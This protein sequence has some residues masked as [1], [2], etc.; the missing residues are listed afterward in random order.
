MIMGTEKLMASGITGES[1]NGS[2]KDTTGVI[3][4]TVKNFFR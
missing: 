4:N 3:N 1:M 2:E